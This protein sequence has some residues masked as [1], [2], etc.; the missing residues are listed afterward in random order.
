M[1]Q[2]PVAPQ[3][4][5]VHHEHGIERSDNYHWLKDK[6]SSESLGY[7]RAE[8]AYYDEQ[9]KPLAGLVQELTDE[10]VGRVPASEVSARWREGSYEYFTRVK[11]ER[12]FS[13]LVRVDATG[14]ETVVLDQNEL[15]GDSS[16]VEVG[17]QLVSPDGARLA[18][19]VDTAGNEV[20]ELRFRD[21]SS[22]QDLPDRVPHTYY[23][24]AWSADGQTF[25]YVVHDAKY[26]PYQVWRHRL[27]TDPSHDV[28]VYEDPDEEYYVTA[29]ADRAGDLIVIFSYSTNTT[30]VWLADAQRAEE[31]AWVVTPRER[32][33]DYR[34]AHRPGPDGGDVLVVTNDG[35]ALERRLMAAPRTTS[36]RSEWRELI[37]ASADLRIHDVDVFARHA[38]VTCV[39]DARQ[40]L[41]VFSLDKLAD[42]VS[43]N[44]GMVIEAETSGGLITLWH[45][46]EPR[47]RLD[48][49]PSGVVHEPGRMGQRQPRLRC[50]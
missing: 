14:N 30:E 12:E 16:Y 28:K 8:R 19:S 44:D 47:G 29:W 35:D 5:I 32:G 33:V 24:G 50:A 38:V 18:Y 45:N 13:E 23:G 9:M 49:G 2:P 17:V 4:P 40:Q 27:G 48:P 46:E 21:L 34:V 3:H 31:P 10:M 11:E 20:Y 1:S 15:L 22:G 43:I 26:R 25:F 7:L 36:D 6:T 39:T 37:P 42:E 41:R